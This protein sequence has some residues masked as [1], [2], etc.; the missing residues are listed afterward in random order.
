MGYIADTQKTDVGYIRDI[1]LYENSQYL[2]MDMSTRRNLELCETMLTKD[3]KGS[4]LWVLDKTGTAMGARLLRNVIEHPLTNVKQIV[5][6]QRSVSELVSNFV[7]REEIR[8]TLGG[9]LDLERLMTKIM[10]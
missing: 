1:E 10:Y 7:L 9:V 2:E 5:S 3:R 4:L 8:S 6:R